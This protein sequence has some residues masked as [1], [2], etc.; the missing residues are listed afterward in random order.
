MEKYST[1]KKIKTGYAHQANMSVISN[2][3][4]EEAHL[5]AGV[6]VND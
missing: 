1:G 4:Y 3:S 5:A 2:P 6:T